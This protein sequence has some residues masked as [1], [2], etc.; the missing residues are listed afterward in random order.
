MTIATLCLLF[1]APALVLSVSALNRK[2]AGRI[3]ET[4]H[5]S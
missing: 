1:L 5:K 3:G 4:E 2:R